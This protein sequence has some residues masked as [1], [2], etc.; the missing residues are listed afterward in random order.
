[1]SAIWGAAVVPLTIPR[2]RPLTRLGLR[3]HAQHEYCKWA[4]S[5]LDCFC[6]AAISK[7]SHLRPARWSRYRDRANNVCQQDQRATSDSAMRR[8]SGSRRT[9]FGVGIAALI[10]VF[11]M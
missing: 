8:P 2:R 11:R 10:L 7:D 9:T 1:M 6:A 4:D 5:S 3:A